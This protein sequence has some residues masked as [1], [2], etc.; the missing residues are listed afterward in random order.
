MFIIS[1]CPGLIV[2]IRYAVYLRH[3]HSNA[4]VSIWRAE[5]LVRRSRTS[6]NTK[7]WSRTALTTG[8]CWGI[9]P[10]NRNKAT[11]FRWNTT[12]SALRICKSL[13]IRYFFR[14]TDPKQSFCVRKI[15]VNVLTDRQNWPPMEK[16][17]PSR[18]RLTLCGHREVSPRNF[19]TTFC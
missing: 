3:R 18:T 2:Y 14:E 17:R 12:S 13:K 1:P 11:T 6:S 8:R 16:S 9:R 15:C 7:S 19:G 10:V 4:P 5:I